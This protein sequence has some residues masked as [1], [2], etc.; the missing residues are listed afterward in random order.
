MA[1]E[2]WQIDSSHSGIHFSVRHMV[3]AKVR[4][5]FARWSGT[6]VAPDGDLGRAT[7]SVVIDATSIDTGVADRDAHL[8]SADFFD[9][10]RYP[11]ITF[12]GTRVEP[13]GHDR[14]RVGGELT[15]RGVTRPVALEVE[16]AGRTID[17]WGHERAGFAAKTSLERKDF[18][19]TWNQLLEAGGVV[20]GDRVDIEID[21]EAV[22]QTAAQAA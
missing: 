16:V 3:V 18:G 7:V 22:R 15:I 13:L 9:V 20:V 4:G 17:P 12:T 5:Q 8:K 10:A 1:H 21:I 14:L 6:L 11:E 19:L 2:E